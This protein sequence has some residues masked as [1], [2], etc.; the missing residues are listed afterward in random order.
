MEIGNCTV[1]GKVYRD[2]KIK[3]SCI[4]EDILSLVG[5]C[6]NTR[7]IKVWIMCQ[8]SPGPSQMLLDAPSLLNRP[9]DSVSLL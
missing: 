2:L 4:G 6:S 7:N 1:I 9:M 3:K 8:K 5:M